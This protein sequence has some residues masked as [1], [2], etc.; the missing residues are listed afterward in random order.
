[1]TITLGWKSA[2]TA[3]F[4]VLV[5]GLGV[6]WAV[7]SAK[8]RNILDF[9]RTEEIQRLKAEIKEL[10]NSAK[11]Y[12]ED[13]DKLRDERDALKEALRMAQEAFKAPRRPEVAPS[14]PTPLEADCGAYVTLLEKSLELA[15]KEVFSLR[16]SVVLLNEAWKKEEARY[17]LMEKRYTALERSQRQAKRRGI[18]INVGMALGS[19]AALTY[20]L[21]K[22]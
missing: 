15:D 16:G 11:D 5:L 18:W 8:Q 14:P 17:D 21:S 4:L 12:H 3:V 2:V 19:V 13:A 20:G 7:R 6:F 10:R 22:L 1:M 9:Q